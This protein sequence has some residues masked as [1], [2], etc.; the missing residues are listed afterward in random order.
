MA[1]GGGYYPDT[2]ISDRDGHYLD[3]NPDGSLNVTSTPA[4]G[5][6]TR[7][8]DGTDQLVINANGSLPAEVL[9]KYTAITSAS[10]ART[11]SG[12]TGLI[13]LTGT[14]RYVSFNIAITAVSG[15]SPTVIWYFQYS[16]ANGIMT[17][18]VPRIAAATP[19]AG[20]NLKATFGPD[21]PQV[22]ISTP[23]AGTV[24]SCAAPAIFNPTGNVR[25][26]WV[27]GGTTPSITFQYGIQQ[28][29]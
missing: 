15:T 18:L 23:A 4:A 2:K 11:A 19:S 22:A 1:P 24:A 16:D 8:T 14:P 12:D 9:P 28:V 13:A 7:I 21:C 20:T 3:I 29:Y 27:I 6:S 25:L 5:S 26:G 17:D 10:S